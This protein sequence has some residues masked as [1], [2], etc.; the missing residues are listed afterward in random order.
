MADYSKYSPYSQT[1]TY[2]TFLDILDYRP[3]PIMGDDVE[4]TI[5]PFYQYR[6]DLLAHDLYDNAGLWWVFAARNPNVLKDPVF[7]FYSGQ[8]IFIP[9]KDALA[10]S[11]GI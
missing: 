10:A 5:D 9:K 8:I 1:P 11:L 4:Y 2:G 3:I 7:D 6:P